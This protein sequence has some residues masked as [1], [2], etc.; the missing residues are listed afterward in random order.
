MSMQKQLLALQKKRVEIVQGMETLV[1]GAEAEERGFNEEE[2]KQFGSAKSELTLLDDRI[3]KVEETAKLIAENAHQV[4]PKDELD[5]AE[6]SSCGPNVQTGSKT[7]STPGSKRPEVKGGFFA[8]QAFFLYHAQG[9][10]MIAADLAE[11]AG[12]KDMGAVLRATAAAADTTTATWAAELVNQKV[13]DFID[14]LR[15]RSVFSRVPSENDVSF[16]DTNSIKMPR[17]TT[18]TPGA[19]VAEG[20]AIPV[21]QG[22]F[23]SL[24][25]TPSKMGVIT[26]AT[27]ELFARSNPSVETILRNMMLNDTAVVQDRR[28][29]SSLAA[30][31]GAP[32]GLFHTD[33]AVAAIAASNT[34]NAGDDAVADMEALLGAVFTANV[35]VGQ[36]VWLMHSTKKLRL[37]N[38]RTAVG[39]FIFRDEL[40]AGTLGGYPVI[41]S[42]VF[43]FGLNNGGASNIKTVALVDTSMLMKGFGIAPTVKLS[44]EATLHMSD[45]PAGD[46]G[47]AGDPT[48]VRSMYQTDSIALRLMWENTWRTRLTAAVQHID[49]V[50]W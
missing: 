5:P 10:Q 21:K 6:R 30:G 22:A 42:T 35:P 11:R 8:R 9:N 13:Q 43:D 19:Y 7:G 45:T 48:P 41:D 34:A 40:A 3:S 33:N 44:E 18:G 1:S 37:S 23:G 46:L 36:L 25:M 31:S 17:A 39:E 38:M 2:Q 50:N 49:N 15:P 16:A 29:L 12:E 26:V 14:L 20:A 47:G 28:F 4:V 27:R 32:A 24:T